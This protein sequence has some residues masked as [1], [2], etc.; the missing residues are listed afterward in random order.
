MCAYV[1]I[2]KYIHTYIHTYIHI[3]IYMRV[4]L[5]VC[6]YIYIYICI[7]T[8]L[9]ICTN[10]PYLFVLLLPLLVY[11]CM[12]VCMYVFMYVCM[13]VR[14]NI[15]RVVRHR[16]CLDEQHACR[17]S[18]LI[19]LGGWERALLDPYRKLILIRAIKAPYLPPLT[20]LMV[21]LYTQTPATNHTSNHGKRRKET[22]IK[23]KP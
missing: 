17:C 13:Y 3:Y 7:Y 9:D 6:L 19:P 1:Y 14:R 12:H 10:I 23:P 21:S 8:C 22:S 11:V 16:C 20:L 18:L 5:F 4:C 2:Y 15:H